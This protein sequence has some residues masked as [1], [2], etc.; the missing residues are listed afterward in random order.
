MLKS[1]VMALLAAM[2]MAFYALPALSLPNEQESLT[3]LQKLWETSGYAEPGKGARTM[4]MMHM[5]DSN[6]DS[7]V[8]KEEF[9]TYHERI[10]DKMDKSMHTG[11]YA[12]L[13]KEGYMAYHEMIWDM[14]DENHKGYINE[15]DW[16][17]KEL[18]KPGG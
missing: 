4:N 1:V 2:T 16:M 6:K 15:Q 3:E 10:W 9:M 14:M 5:M 18:K 8:T 17:G 13:N 12:K 11:K 7:K